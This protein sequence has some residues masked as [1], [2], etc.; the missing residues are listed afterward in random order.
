MSPVVSVSGYRY[1]VLF[2]NDYTRYSWIFPMR[3]KYEVFGH[4]STFAIYV[5]T[6][7]SLSVKQFQSDGGKEYDNL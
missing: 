3:L 7:F 4:F 5:K 2:T 1:Y 6:Q